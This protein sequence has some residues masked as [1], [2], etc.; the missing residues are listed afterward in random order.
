[1]FYLGIWWSRNG[2]LGRFHLILHSGGFD[3]WACCVR[4]N[5][6]GRVDYERLVICDRVCEC[7]SVMYYLQYLG[8]RKLRC[9]ARVL[10]HTMST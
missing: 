10:F 4:W 7:T 2:C 9:N 6:E 3:L 1:M 8:P 5:R